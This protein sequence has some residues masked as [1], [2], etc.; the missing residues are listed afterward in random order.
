MRR[1]AASWLIRPG[2]CPVSTFS[3][4][5]CHILDGSVGA[6]LFTPVA[7]SYLSSSFGYLFI[8]ILS[9]IG[10]LGKRTRNANELLI[11][12]EHKLQLKL[13]NNA[14]LLKSHEAKVK[15]H[16][17]L[18]QRHRFQTVG[19]LD[20]FLAQNNVADGLEYSYAEKCNIV[21]EQI[22]LRKKLDGIKKVSGVA[23]SNCSGPDH[24]EPLSRLLDL[25]RLLCAREV[26]H[27]IRPPVRPQLLQG[28]L[29]FSLLFTNS[30]KGT[31]GMIHNPFT[32]YTRSQV[33]IWR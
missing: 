17:K 4:R 27:G 20:E 7:S 25:F 22:Q 24:P 31:L 18:R 1:A 21:R 28:I 32:P 13:D 6:C 26:A 30:T 10:Y 19:E 29:S 2:F 15:E 8:N 3:N 16:L 14:K 9:S 23:L 33:Q 12:D 5:L 11:H